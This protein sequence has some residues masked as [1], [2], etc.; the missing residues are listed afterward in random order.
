MAVAAET[1]C[2]EPTASYDTVSTEIVHLELSRGDPSRY[3]WQAMTRYVLDDSNG[4]ITL[5]TERLTQQLRGSFHN[6]LP[7]TESFWH[8]LLEHSLSEVD[9]HGIAEQLIADFNNTIDSDR[10][11]HR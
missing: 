6:S 5:A 7:M 3:Y 1:E 10:T 9:W 2:I 8:Q 11:A 4:D